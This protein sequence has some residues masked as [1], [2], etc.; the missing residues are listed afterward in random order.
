MEPLVPDM[1]DKEVVGKKGGKRRPIR[2][3]GL[4][5]TGWTAKLSRQEEELECG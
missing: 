4:D 1:E 2:W 3:L 5:H